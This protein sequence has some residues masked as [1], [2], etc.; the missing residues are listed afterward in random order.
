MFFIISICIQLL[1]PLST[2]LQKTK[3]WHDISQYNTNYSPPDLNTYLSTFNCQSTT[4]NCNYI[5]CYPNPRRH[6]SAIS[7]STYTKAQAEAMCNDSNTCDPYCL[8][9]SNITCPT[10]CCNIASSPEQCTSI[11]NNAGVHVEPDEDIMLVFGGI[12]LFNITINETNKDEI[13]KQIYT[14]CTLHSYFNDKLTTPETQHIGNYIANNCGNEVLNE[15]WEYNINKHTWNYIQPIIDDTLPQ[16]Q[17]QKPYPRYA[18]SSIYIE[19]TENNFLHKYMYIYGG[20][21]LTSTEPFSDMWRYE[22]AYFPT[23]YHPT[24]KGNTWTLLTPSDGVHPGPREHH[25]MTAVVRDSV[26]THIYLFGGIRSESEILNDLW[27]YDIYNGTWKEI[28]PRGILNAYRHIMFWNGM[29]TRVS[30]PLEEANFAIDTIETV[31]KAKGI[32]KFPAPRASFGF[33]SVK[34]KESSYVL[35][36]GGFT[37]EKVVNEGETYNFQHHLND[38]WLY[39]ID[40]NLWIETFPLTDVRPSARHSFAFFPFNN[41]RLIL[42][43]GMNSDTIFND[44]WLFNLNSLLWSN[45]N[46]TKH[47]RNDDTDWPRPVKF[48]TFI[49]TSSLSSFIL[50]GGNV[51]YSSEYNS[52]TQ[53]I[54]AI[55]QPEDTN[56]MFVDSVWE[57]KVKDCPNNCSN[58]GTC[59]FGRCVCDYGYWGENCSNV[60]CPYSLCYSDLDMFDEQLCYHC[61]SLGE[62]VNGTCVCYEGYAGEDCSMKECPNNCSGEENGRCVYMKPTSQCECNQSKRRGGDDCSVTF[63]LNTCGTHGEC[64]E[65]SGVCVCEKGYYGEDCSM[66]VISFR[67]SEGV[68]YKVSAIWWLW[69]VVVV[70]IMGI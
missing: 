66:F 11:L 48:G 56:Y 51:W 28:V 32:G 40:Q 62:C 46:K 13:L 6:H 38:A 5:P 33:V 37:W 36:Y 35:L 24:N 1:F 61:S 15:I 39:S 57:L 17:Q 31:S 22:L 19:I 21:S 34:I 9:H 7:Y 10:K 27:I 12:S 14:N 25:A 29:T 16:Q 64:D 70:V 58:K 42:Y 68:Y 20:M 2:Q 50:Y 44:L 54:S 18:H 23:K 63:C 26:Y 59:D 8:T 4:S 30:I 69:V 52:T 67:A 53:S 47:D 41:E 3:I 55:I 49:K 43:G 45:I 60:Y 65:H